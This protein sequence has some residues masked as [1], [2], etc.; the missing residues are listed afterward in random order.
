MPSPQ[1]NTMPAP[2]TEGSKATGDAAA[3][4]VRGRFRV[5]TFD[6]GLMGTT[7]QDVENHL[8][9]VAIRLIRADILNK[10]RAHTVI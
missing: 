1:S 2:E 5:N 7:I 3:S 4:H 6:R 10:K 9:I 8:Q